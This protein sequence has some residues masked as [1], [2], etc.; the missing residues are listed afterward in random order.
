MHL[1]NLAAAVALAATALAAQAQEGWK[2]GTATAA[3]TPREPIWMAGYGARNRPSE[4][5]RQELWVKA[6][7]LQEAGAAPAVIVTADLLGFT[8][9]MSAAVAERCLKQYGIPRE[10]LVLAA[11]HTHSGPVAGRMLLPAYDLPPGQLKLIDAYTDDFIA[12][13]V[14]VVGEAIAGLRPASLAFGQGLAGFGV[15]RRRTGRRN[16]PGPV[17]Q[18]V[19]VLTVR[20]PEGTLR[21]V[22]FGY[23]CHNTSMSDYKFNGDYAGYAMVEIEK[24]HPGAMALYAAGAGAD[25]NPLP[26]VQT[27]DALTAMYGKILATAVELVLKGRMKPVGGPLAARFQTVDLPFHAP[28][29]REQLQA[30]LKDPD[31]A[32]LRHTRFLLAAIERDGRLPDRYPYPLQVWKF[33]KDLTWIVMGGEVVVDYALRLKA[34]YGWEN[35]WVTGYANDVFAYIPSLRVLQEGGYEG[36]GAMIPYGQPGPFGAAVEEIV[37]EKIAD[38]A[39]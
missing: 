11:S 21:A 14:T 13:T 5:V 30:R 38:L 29:T 6:L 3:I 39:R 10:R 19:P 2:A 17:D 8:R 28:P 32:R 36:G 22:L 27:N 18:D 1:R 37:V 34:Q 24:A 23:A 7:A 31:P 16:L 20:A 12:R 9:E 4:G 33:G 35:T 15:N 26:R 25:I